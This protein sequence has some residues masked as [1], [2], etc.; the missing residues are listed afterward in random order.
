MVGH[1]E[2]HKVNFFEFR[3]VGV[4]MLFKEISY[5]E[6]WQPLFSAERNHLVN[7]SVKLFW[8]SGSG[9]DVVSRYFLSRALAALL[10]GGGGDAL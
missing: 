3:P 1:Y 8:T 9:A 7:I 2:K 6:L 5:L 10:F 4:Q